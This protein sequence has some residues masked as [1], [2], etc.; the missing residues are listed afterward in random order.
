MRR[1]RVPGPSP[2]GVSP[3]A[4]GVRENTRSASTHIVTATTRPI[5]AAASGKPSEPIAATHS[6][7]KMTPPMLPPL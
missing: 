1:R 4:S 6:G 3:I 5:A 2:S 7:E